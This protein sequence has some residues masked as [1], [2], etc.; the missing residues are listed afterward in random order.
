MCL[1][2]YRKHLL[3]KLKHLPKTP[4]YTVRVVLLRN[5]HI[6]VLVHDV[7]RTMESCLRWWRKPVCT[8]S[9]AKIQRYRLYY[10]HKHTIPHQLL[11]L[12]IIITVLAVCNCCIDKLVSRSPFSAAATFASLVIYR[13]DRCFSTKSSLTPNSP[14]LKMSLRWRSRSVRDCNMKFS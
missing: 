14:T 13:Y 9:E 7:F 11:H 10:A 12:T 3:I 5:V 2:V 4:E 1:C 6:H 8:S